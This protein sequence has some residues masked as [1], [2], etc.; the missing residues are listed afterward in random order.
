M[1]FSGGS[2]GQAASIAERTEQIEADLLRQLDRMNKVQLDER[3]FASESWSALV[4]YSKPLGEPVMG[5]PDP[6]APLTGR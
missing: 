3:L 4:D 2:A 1:D 6:F 5:R